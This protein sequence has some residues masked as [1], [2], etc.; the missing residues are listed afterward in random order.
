MKEY[1]T[2]SIYFKKNNTDFKFYPNEMF[3]W[4]ISEGYDGLEYS[5]NGSLD[6]VSEITGL[7]SPSNY[8]LLHDILHIDNSASLYAPEYNKD[9]FLSKYKV[10]KKEVFSEFDNYMKRSY[11]SYLSYNSLKNIGLKRVEQFIILLA[12]ISYSNTKAYD[13]LSATFVEKRPI[14]LTIQS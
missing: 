6:S 8:R 11:I 13:N 12:S 2:D 10:N 3:K 4:K 7:V 9:K 14:N 1:L 5:K